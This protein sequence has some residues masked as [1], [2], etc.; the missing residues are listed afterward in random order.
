MML[1]IAL[2]FALRMTSVDDAATKYAQALESGTP[3][4]VSAF[5]AA[6]GELQ[7]P[8]MEA[9]HGPAAIKAFLAPMAATIVVDDATM[10]SD[11]TSTTGGMATQFGHYTQTAGERGKEHR[12]YSGRFAALWRW[13]G[14]Q[15]K[16]V[17]LMMQPK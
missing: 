9:L 6:D 10:T 5:F 8:G 3:D 12:Q 13:N 14:E 17:R 2:L 4:D 16:I 11:L 15:W 1:A 7:L